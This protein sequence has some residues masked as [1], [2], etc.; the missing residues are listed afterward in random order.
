MYAVGGRFRADSCVPITLIR[1]MA[2]KRKYLAFDI[3]TA[4]L[5]ENDWRSC[6]PLGIPCA[7]TLLADSDEPILWHGGNDR[8]CPADRM[9]R[10]EAVKLVKYLTTQVGRGYAILTWNGVGFDFDVLAEEAQMLAECRDLALAHVDMM[11]HVLCKLG[12]GVGLDAAARGMGIAGKTEGMKGADAPVPWAEGRR[13]EVLWYVAQ[14]VRIT[15][16][17]A[18]TCESCGAFRWVARSGKLAFM[19]LPEGWLTVEAA[20]RCRCLIRHG[21]TSR[22]RG[23]GSRRGW[24]DPSGRHFGYLSRNKR[25]SIAAFA[26]EVEWKVN[27]LAASH[28]YLS[29]RGE[30][31]LTW[32][33]SPSGRN[34]RMRR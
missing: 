16:E 31:D 22:G 13:K 28:R 5:P 21:W 32:T 25:R 23:R 3:E 27:W 10:E 20:V 30:Y 1:V 4:K 24:G 9:N 17:L 34:S 19:T 7:A 26:L 15:M 14:D 6:R 29:Y 12:Y 33:V 18:T 8:T 2:T 11:F